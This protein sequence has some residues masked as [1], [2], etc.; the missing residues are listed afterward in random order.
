MGRCNGELRYEDRMYDATATDSWAICTQPKVIRLGALHFPKLIPL[1]RCI[2]P[3]YNHS[4]ILAW[5]ETTYLFLGDRGIY[6][7]AGF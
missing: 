6:G 5:G 1:V 4:R 3:T 2:R 7:Y